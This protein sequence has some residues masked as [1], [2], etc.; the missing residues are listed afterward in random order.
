MVSLMILPLDPEE[1][2][3]ISTFRGEQ[4]GPT[5]STDIVGKRKILPAI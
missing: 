5:T 3:S 4:V 1:N 2:F